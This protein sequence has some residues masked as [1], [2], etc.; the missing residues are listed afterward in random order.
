MLSYLSGNQYFLRK[1]I[2]IYKKLSSALEKIQSITAL[3]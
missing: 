3:M 2:N 1:Y